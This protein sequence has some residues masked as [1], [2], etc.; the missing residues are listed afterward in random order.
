M[1]RSGKIKIG[2]SSLGKPH[3]GNIDLGKTRSAFRYNLGAVETTANRVLLD[4]S[5]DKYFTVCL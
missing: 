3:L 4:I 1:Q 5:V 2:K